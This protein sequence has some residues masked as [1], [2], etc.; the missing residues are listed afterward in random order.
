MFFKN[1]WPAFVWAFVILILCI[2]PGN[3]LPNL[4]FWNIDK[5]GHAGI[6]GILSCLLIYGFAKQK[7]FQLLTLKPFLTSILFSAFYGGLIEIIQELIVYK[8][9]G[10]M[11]DFIADTL[12]AIV[13][14]WLFSIYGKRFLPVEEEV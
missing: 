10:D 4:S 12:G 5:L 7:R 11:Y 14:A 2:I 9:N 3:E 8:R 13:F 1:L 6:F